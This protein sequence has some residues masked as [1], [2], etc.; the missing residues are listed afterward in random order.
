MQTKKRFIILLAC[1]SLLC[2]WFFLSCDNPSGAGDGTGDGTGDGKKNENQD[3]GQTGNGTDSEVAGT[4]SGIKLV[5]GDLPEGTKSIRIQTMIEDKTYNLFEISDL[6]KYSYVIDENVTKGQS[7]QYRFIYL[8]EGN[9]WIDSSNWKTIKADGGKGEKDLKATPTSNGIK[10]SGDI[11]EDFYRMELERYDND[12]SIEIYLDKSAADPDGSFTDKLVDAGK[13]YEYRLVVTVGAPRHWENGKKIQ[14]DPLVQYPRYKPIKV[15]AT[16]GSGSIKVNTLPK[17]EYNSNNKTITLTQ[18]PVFSVTPKSWW[19]SLNYGNANIG[20]Y[21]FAEFGSWNNEKNEAVLEDDISDGYWRFSECWFELYFDNYSY[22][23]YVY[24]VPDVPE[25]I[26][27]N[28]KMEDLFIPTVKATDEGIEISWDKSKLPPETETIWINT[29]NHW[30][31]ISDL[32]ITSF[33]DKYVEAGKTYNYDIRASKKNG[34]TL[35]QGERV[36]IKAISGKGKLKIENDKKISVSYD[37]KV[38]AVAFSELPKITGNPSKWDLYFEYN[39]SRGLFGISSDN[40]KLVTNLYDAPAGDWTFTSYCINDYSNP[41]YRYC[42]EDDNLEAF[43]NF[44]ETITISDAIKPRLKATAV[45][46]GIKLEWENLPEQTKRIELCANNKF[47]DIYDLTI[48]SFVDKYV[49]PGKTY[50]Y[51]LRVR[52][53]SGNTTVQSE[54][55]SVKATAGKGKFKIENENKISVTYDEK[56]GEVTFSEL[57][58]ITDNPS[59]WNINFN[60]QKK[61]SNNTNTLFGL[62]SGNNRLSSSLNNASTG[63]W[64]FNGYWI[65]DNSSSKYRYSQ[66]DDNLEV[67]AA[68]FPKTIT[69]TDAYKPKLTASN[70]ENGIKFEWDN[71]PENPKYFAIRIEAKDDSSLI[72][73]RINNKELTSLVAE[74]V[75]AG[76]AYECYLDIKKS[77]DSWITSDHVTITPAK[78]KGELLI[79]N[80]PAAVLEGTDKVSFTTV[81]QVSGLS[82]DTNWTAE[83][84]YTL[85]NNGDCGLYQYSSN[86]GNTISSISSWVEN[87][88][89]TLDEYCVWFGTRQDNFEYF[90][91]VYDISKLNGMPMQIVINKEN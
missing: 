9:G 71:I 7:Y 14:A 69:V 46:D 38:G 3:S 28:V 29:S 82:S 55:V 86:Q 75:T 24:E 80:S 63:E 87:G 53:E 50:E 65:N 44:P 64:T 26:L 90:N 52:N 79:T 8:N 56:E 2:S 36:K 45:D 15:T 13:E 22:A 43:T 4:E 16:G 19:M 39:N 1:I 84:R 89:W 58:K 11:P 21:N 51:Y 27:L 34:N 67:F 10:I 78:G 42:Q 30:F 72:D 59:D 85:G 25:A 37:E 83:F 66:W 31:E 40:Q 49:E 73:Y 81:P 54:S 32:T 18:K 41:A 47:I 57:P 23:F 12:Y 62:S 77:N 61:N 88:N 60:Y 33:L 17:A 5:W 6:S 68:T 20:S 35:L 48:D 91:Y 70:V 74:Y 76:K